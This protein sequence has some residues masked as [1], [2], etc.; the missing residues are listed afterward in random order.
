MQGEVPPL[1]AKIIELSDCKGWITAR[2]TKNGIRGL[3][4]TLPDQIRDMFSEL[5]SM[6]HGEMEGIGIRLK[7]RTKTADTVDICRQELSTAETPTPKRFQETVDTVDKISYTSQKTAFSFCLLTAST[8]LASTAPTTSTASLENAEYS[9]AQSLQVSTDGLLTATQD[10]PVGEIFLDALDPFP[11]VSTVTIA[12]LENA[13]FLSEQSLWCVDTM[14]T[15]GLQRSTDEPPL[16]R[17]GDFSEF[18]I[19]DR[20]TV[21]SIS[22]W[23]PAT[24]LA[25]PNPHPNPSQRMTAWKARLDTGQEIYVWDI[26]NICPLNVEGG[27]P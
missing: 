11:I 21:K 18:E 26:R 13:E 12:S 20:V 25:I 15:H 22:T 27:M 17:R 2:D 9:I 6:G 24:L 19:G 5:V 14:S 7:F 10:S 8:D 16:E 23:Q 1:L 3:K 4:A